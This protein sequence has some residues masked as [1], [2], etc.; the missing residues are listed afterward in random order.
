MPVYVEC[1]PSIPIQNGDPG[2]KKWQM[3]FATAVTA[4]SLLE[5]S[6]LIKASKQAFVR[7]LLLGLFSADLQLM[8]AGFV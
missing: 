6:E 1:T 8:I 2:S 3:E 5:N 4:K 7:K